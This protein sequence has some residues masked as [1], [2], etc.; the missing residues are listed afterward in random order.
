MNPHVMTLLKCVWST[1][2]TFRIHISGA[3]RGAEKI[4]FSG[5]LLY[6]FCHFLS[7][8][9]VRFRTDS[10]SSRETFN[11]CARLQNLCAKL[12]NLRTRLQNLRAKLSIFARDYRIFARTFSVYRAKQNLSAQIAI[13]ILFLRA[14]RKRTSRGPLNFFARSVRTSRGLKNFFARDSATATLF[15]C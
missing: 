15:S 5:L 6:F 2:P 1:R 4:N 14:G 3:H 11:F 10:E 9:S 13:S 12:L 7:L 8:L